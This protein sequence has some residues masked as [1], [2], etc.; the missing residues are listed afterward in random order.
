[1]TTVFLSASDGFVITMLAIIGLSMGVV[2]LL[3]VCM[4]RNAAR[5]DPLVDELLEEVAREEEEE[6]SRA[7]AA[8]EEPNPKPA[9]PWVRE[10][11]WWKS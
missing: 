8:R 6:E 3:F 10:P 9:E 1:M 5:R 4:R 7:A 2:A 11:D